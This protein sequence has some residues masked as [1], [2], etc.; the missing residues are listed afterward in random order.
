M[1]KF[2]FQQPP[3]YKQ[4]KCILRRW[5]QTVP[6][7]R[8]GDTECTVAN[9]S[10]LHPRD[11]QSGRGRGS[12]PS[13]WLQGCHQLQLVSKVWRSSTMETME[14]EHR[15]FELNALRYRQPVQFPEE[16]RYVLVLP[17]GVDQP[18]S[19][20]K[21]RLKAHCQPSTHTGELRGLQMRQW[22]KETAKMQ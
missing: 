14:N 11:V 9:G 5:W 10:P 20:V 4:R 19:G 17:F 16:W 6:D 21:N 12:Q 15:K 18:S 13:A 1:K 8:T 22:W 7:T 2:T 3:K